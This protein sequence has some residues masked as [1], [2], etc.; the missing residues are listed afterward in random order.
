MAITDKARKIL[1]GRS[2]N[3]CTMCRH[4]LVIDATIVDDESVVGDECHI[5][6]GQGQGPR[7]D[8]VFPV[9]WLDEPDNLILLCR[10]HHKMVDDQCETYTVALLRELKKN[11]EKWVSTTLSEKS[12]PPRVR[13][14][15]IKKNIPCHLIRATSGQDVMNIVGTAYSY[16]FDHDEPQSEMEMELIKGF[17]Q[18]VQDSSDFSDDLE[19]GGRV[20]AAYSMTN[21]IRELEQA[22]FWVFVAREVQQIEGSSGFRARRP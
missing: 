11:H 16:G 19:A 9:E 17:L 15:R 1:W 18:D 14:R 22:G 8:S 20:E 21:R 10:V 5:I 2:G 12:E 6:S 3:S 4:E 13:I 7:Y